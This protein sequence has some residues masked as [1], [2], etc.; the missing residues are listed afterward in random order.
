MKAIV[1]QN[2]TGATYA[3]SGSA[4]IFG[5]SAVDFAA[6]VGAATAVLTFVVNLYF[7]WKADQRADAEQG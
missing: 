6:Y 1:E 2:I 7:K 3:A 4:V 5:L